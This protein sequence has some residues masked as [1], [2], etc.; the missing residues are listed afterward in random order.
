MII[1]AIN[2]IN[3]ITNVIYQEA[4]VSINADMSL[5]R[6]ISHHTRKHAP[7]LVCGRGNYAF[8]WGV[9]STVCDERFI[10]SNDDDDDGF[11]MWW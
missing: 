3:T 4:F 1:T 7:V 2:T 6:A 9:R 5:Q 8:T 10:N 11:I